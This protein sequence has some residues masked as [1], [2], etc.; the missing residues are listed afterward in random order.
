[1]TPS[2][3]KH[4]NLFR[5]FKLGIQGYLRIQYLGDWARLLGVTGYF[6]ELRFVEVRHAGVQRK[7]RAADPKTLTF[8]LQA[9]R[10]LGDQFG[11][12]VARALQLKGCLLYTSDAADE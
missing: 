7:R 4:L 1:M 6:P 5:R 3:N 11:G 9:D 10:R 2:K 8:R 12:C